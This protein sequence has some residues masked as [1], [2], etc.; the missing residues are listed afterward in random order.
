MFWIVVLLE[1]EERWNLCH[2]MKI[3][4]TT[5]FFPFPPV[6]LCFGARHNAK[7]DFH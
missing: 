3:N 1:M 5:V 6:A 4:G 7:G 2:G